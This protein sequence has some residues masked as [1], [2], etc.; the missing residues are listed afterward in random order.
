[1][2][3]CLLGIRST[4]KII[5]IFLNLQFVDYILTL[6]EKSWDNIR[7]FKANLIFVERNFGSK[8]NFHKSLLTR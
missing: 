7:A 4:L 1:M 5:C 2:S 3:V 6:G 8:V